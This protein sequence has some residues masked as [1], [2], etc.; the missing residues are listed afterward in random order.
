MEEIK[1]DGKRTW[2]GNRASSKKRPGDI[3]K[4]ITS[5]SKDGSRESRSPRKAKNDQ[6]IDHDARPRLYEVV[7]IVKVFGMCKH[8]KK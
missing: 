5:L 6:L 4:Q 3:E 1:G 7:I 2:G 8:F